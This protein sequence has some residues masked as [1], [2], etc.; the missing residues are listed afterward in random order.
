VETPIGN[1]PERDSLDVAGLDVDAEDMDE[2]LRVDIRGW[3][4]EATG[5]RE[6]YGEFGDHVPAA[7]REELDALEQ[8]LEAASS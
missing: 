6:Y 2:L 4:A 5:I 1:L 7:L 3:L 8:R